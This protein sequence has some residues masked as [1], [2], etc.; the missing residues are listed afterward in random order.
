MFEN[1]E[2]QEMKNMIDFILRPKTFKDIEKI[3]NLILMKAASLSHSSFKG[4]PYYTGEVGHAVR[5]S[6]RRDLVNNAKNYAKGR[7]KEINAEK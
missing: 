1:T 5:K 7:L 2:T 4:G 3:T 6:W